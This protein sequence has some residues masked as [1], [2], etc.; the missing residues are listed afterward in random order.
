[1]EESTKTI[2]VVGATG[3]LGRLILQALLEAPNTRVRALVRPGSRG[4][5]TGELAADEAA[6]VEIV[7]GELG[8]PAALA[9]ACAG[10]FAV[11]S[12]VQGGPEII[13]DGQ[14]ALLAAA[15]DA[16]VRRMIPSDYSVDLFRLA[17]G[18]NINSDW[19]RTFAERAEA[20]RGDVALVHVFNGCFL[21]KRVL[22]GFLG[23]FDLAAGTMNL[24]GEGRAPMDFTT[25][26]DTARYTARAAIAD[27]VPSV[28]R[29]A[30]DTLDFWQLKEAVEEVTGR[31]LSVR[32]QG[33]L[34][35]LDAEIDRRR[36]AAPTDLFAWLPLMY[37]RGMLNGKG[38][39]LGLDNQRFP[40]VAPTDL[41]AYVR[42]EL[43]GNP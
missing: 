25:F 11:V 9:R 6:R 36:A 34:A 31:T 24:W 37:W 21:D 22:F 30:G 10:A 40:E 2:L 42:A 16:G 27:E 3:S 38:Q 7:D 35:E 17:P 23:A 28:V 13:V 4:K 1:M 15:R 29:V 5:L 32:H 26:R 20:I 39:L 19:R 33:T 12:A 14:L 41:R 8:D 43:V 18:E